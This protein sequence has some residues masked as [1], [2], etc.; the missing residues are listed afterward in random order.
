[1]HR[2]KVLHLL[3]SITLPGI[4]TACGGSDGDVNSEPQPNPH[5]P[6]PIDPP[7]T[8]VGLAAG[9]TTAKVLSN[10][11]GSHVFLYT[12]AKLMPNGAGKMLLVYDP[13]SGPS[14]YSINVTDGTPTPLP[15]PDFGALGGDANGVVNAI[16]NT[17]G[18]TLWMGFGSGSFP[19]YR[20]LWAETDAATGVAGPAKQ[21]ALETRP[22]PQ[23]QLL[24]QEPG[25]KSLMRWNP[26]LRQE[27]E[28]PFSDKLLMISAIAPDWNSFI[29]LPD[30]ALS[31]DLL[32]SAQAVFDPTGTVW[33]VHP[34][35][36]PSANEWN[37]VIYSLAPNATTWTPHLTIP[38]ESARSKD[39]SMGIDS[40]GRIV[41]GHSPA[42]AEPFTP[43]PFSISRFDPARSEWTAITTPGFTIKWLF[44]HVDAPGNIWMFT[45]DG[46][47]RYD[48]QNGTWVH[49]EKF[50]YAPAD[51]API[52]SNWN[53]LP[54]ATDSHGNA[55]VVGTR[56][57]AN[58]DQ[59]LPLLWIN[60]FDAVTR[61]WGEAA[62]L[63]VSGGEDSVFIASANP[64]RTDD[65]NFL[66]SM[67]MDS[68]ERP[69]A[70]I[71]ES[72]STGWPTGQF[73]RAWVTRGPVSA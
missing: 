33:L 66:V 27:N 26:G 54:I 62:T 65:S 6:T 16:P 67:A 57:K 58:R 61:Q 3:G 72:V 38:A 37:L 4:L 31:A 50:D 23:A 20:F 32:Q 1:M 49:P 51:S 18:G 12:S 22:W 59:D 44:L 19:T 39:F 53:P 63:H 40:R 5:D 17:L 55:W 71:T 42:S 45:D 36:E 15:D 46:Y 56:R 29:G 10:A 8:S 43:R 14:A 35:P 13:I 48:D 7:S 25:G 73:S 70:L 69:V 64:D 52:R 68:L 21:S 2:R 60:R 11:T 30:P 47:A 41:V 9:W 28:E 34:S 24:T